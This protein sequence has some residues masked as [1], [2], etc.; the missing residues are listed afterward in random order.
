MAAALTVLILLISRTVFPPT[1]NPPNGILPL[2]IF[3]GF[4]D[5]LAFGVGIGIL[6]YVALHFSRWPK[7]IRGPIWLMFFLALWFSVLNWVHD[8]MHESGAAAP[9]WQYLAL[10]EIIFHVP[11]LLFAVGLVFAA[12][13]IIRAK[14]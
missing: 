13:S 11:W 7:E 8:G 1:D 3:F 12:R 10:T 4:W 14:Q 5:A 9:N 6:I 2:F